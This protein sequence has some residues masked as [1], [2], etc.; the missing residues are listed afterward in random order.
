MAFVGVTLIVGEPAASLSCAAGKSVL[1]KRWVPTPKEI[2][3]SW[4]SALMAGKRKSDA[5][6]AGGASGASLPRSIA[7]RFSS[8]CVL[9]SSACAAFS[10][11]I[12][13]Y[14]LQAS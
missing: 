8:A 13:A 5:G 12:P 14:V 9:F 10:S 6:G 2:P 1:F 4:L 7:C 3:A 11:L